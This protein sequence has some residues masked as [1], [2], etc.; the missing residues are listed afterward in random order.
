MNR[1]AEPCVSMRETSLASVPAPAAPTME[2]DVQRVAELPV[3]AG[4]RLLR[5][6][7]GR[8]ATGVVVVSTGRGETLHAMTANAFMSGSLR[9][10][11]IVVSVGQRA[12]MHDRLMTHEFFAVSVLTDEQEAHSRH[13]AGEH[14][15]WLAPHF[16]EAQG[17]P[18]IAWLDRAVARFAARVVDRHP[19][20]DHTL[21]IGEV[22]AFSLEDHAPLLFFGGHYANVRH[23]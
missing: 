22:Q 16:S 4:E 8:F 6:A 3:D 21:F 18:G 5:R 19:C 15:T 9:P 12:R 14:Q 10:P 23:P 2:P 20:G 7:F 1:I 11:L 17:V 13:Y